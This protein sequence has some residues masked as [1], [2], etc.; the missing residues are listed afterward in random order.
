M[1]NI[2]ISINSYLFLS[3]EKYLKF[4]AGISVKNKMTSLVLIDS[5]EIHSKRRRGQNKL[6]RGH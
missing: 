1:T 6:I 4:R 5:F 2:S 3:L